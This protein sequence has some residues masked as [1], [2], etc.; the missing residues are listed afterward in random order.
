MLE[1]SEFAI[2]DDAALMADLKNSVSELCPT[3]L[4][5]FSG[6]GTSA[7]CFSQTAL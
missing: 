3:W 4:V 7:L 1:S 5:L 2:G 6:D